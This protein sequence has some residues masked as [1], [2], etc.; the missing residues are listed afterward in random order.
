MERIVAGNI[1]FCHIKMD[2]SKRKEDL[3]IF[4]LLENYDYQIKKHDK[5]Y[6]KYTKKRK[7]KKKNSKS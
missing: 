3:S 7:K 5:R 2:K 1:K 4:L 6:T